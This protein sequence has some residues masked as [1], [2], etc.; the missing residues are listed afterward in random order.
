MNRKAAY[1]HQILKTYALLVDF[2]DEPQR[3]NVPRPV[4]NETFKQWRKRV[5]KGCE[6][7]VAVYLPHIPASNTRLRTLQKLSGSE[8]VA[9]VL[10]AFGEKKE[11]KHKRSIQRVEERYASFPKDTLTD[12]LDD[13][14]D[15]LE[16]SVKH[17]FDEYLK[18]TE[19]E[20]DAENL[21][22]ALINTLNNAARLA[23]GK[24]QKPLSNIGA[25]DTNAEQ[26]E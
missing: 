15:E 6:G 12:V 26:T 5:L 24:V 20:I 1:C 2:D 10:R 17:F 23:H 21:L 11:I 7:E 8:N 22:R 19:D 4:G 3:R 13:I 14:G 16:P 25:E 18:H 9:A